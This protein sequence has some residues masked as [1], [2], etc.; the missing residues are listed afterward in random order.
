MKPTPDC[1]F[2]TNFYTD[3]DGFC[4]LW[5]NIPYPSCEMRVKFIRSF[6]ATSYAKTDTLEATLFGYYGNIVDELYS[7]MKFEIIQVTYSFDLV[8]L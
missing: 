1:V 8:K 5:Q 6:Q 4:R 2:P 7:R 3:Q